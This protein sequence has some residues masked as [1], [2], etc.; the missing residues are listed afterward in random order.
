MKSRDQILLEQ[1]YEMTKDNSSKFSKLS[2]NGLLETY[3]DFCD[4]RFNVGDEPGA[5]EENN[6]KLKDLYAEIKK[7]GSKLRNHAD[8]Y[9]SDSREMER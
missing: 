5:E 7:R 1:A 8:W 6:Q 9:E 4:R 3:K 2:D